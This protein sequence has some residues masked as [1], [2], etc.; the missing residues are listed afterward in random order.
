MDFAISALDIPTVR[1]EEEPSSVTTTT[2]Y[3]PQEYTYESVDNKQGPGG[4]EPIPPSMTS[5]P[6]G[7]KAWDKCLE[8]Q[9][10]YVFPCEKGVAL[11]GEFG[12]VNRCNHNA[13]ELIIGGTAAAKWEFPH[14]VLLGYINDQNKIDW[15]CGGA[16]ISDRRNDVSHALIG[17]QNRSEDSAS[18]RYGIK[19]IIKHNNYQSPHKYNDIALLEL[20]RV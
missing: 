17:A 19:R 16:L 4:C 8:Y 9:E 14:M 6:R 1:P 10:K 15:E 11:T 13:D 18:I 12:R 7:Q 2:E 3:T 5:K 20:D